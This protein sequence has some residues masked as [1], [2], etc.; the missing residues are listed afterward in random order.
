MCAW[1]Q[2][3]VQAR[4]PAHSCLDGPASND[5]TDL[6]GEMR[7]SALVDKYRVE[8]PP[9]PGAIPAF[10]FLTVL[11]YRMLE[12]GTINGAR[13]LGLDR[14][15][16]SLEIGKQ[17][18]VVAVKLMAHPVFNP[19]NTLVYVGTNRYASVS[20]GDMNNPLGLSMYGLMGNAS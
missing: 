5:D 6:L 19:V 4:T 7:T 20:T 17:A 18:D 14:M 1:G 13:A 2:V 16:G 9:I 11:A 12:M 3:C 15:I 10:Y 8:D